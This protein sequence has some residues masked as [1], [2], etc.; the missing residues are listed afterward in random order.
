MATKVSFVTPNQPFFDRLDI[1]PNARLLK[2]TLVLLVFGEIHYL[3]SLRASLDRELTQRRFSCA[4]IGPF[5]MQKSD[6]RSRVRLGGIEGGGAGRELSRCELDE[7]G[8]S[9]F[10]QK[11]NAT[12]VFF[13]SL[14]MKKAPNRSI[15]D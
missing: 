10:H 14:A 7:T 9:G 1:F 4:Q 12:R 11:N 2:I 8:G 13:R 3:P 15:K 6:P 5:L